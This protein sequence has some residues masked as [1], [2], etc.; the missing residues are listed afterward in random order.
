MND[1]IM[2]EKDERVGRVYSCISFWAYSIL[3]IFVLQCFAAVA[4]SLLYVKNEQTR[5]FFC[6]FF[7]LGIWMS[8]SIKIRTF[9]DYIRD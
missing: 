6:V 1:F 7:F 5:C 3:W 8:V 2:D 4:K 9:R